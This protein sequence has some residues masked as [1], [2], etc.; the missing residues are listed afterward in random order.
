MRYATP[1]RTALASLAL[2]SVL[3]CGGSSPSA[4][5]PAKPEQ[6]PKKTDVEQAHKEFG[7]AC[8]KQTKGAGEYCECAWGQLKKILGDDLA[9]K[10]DPKLAAQVRDAVADECRAKAPESMIKDGYV[11]GCT[12]QRPEMEDYCNCT[13]TEFRKRYSV[14]DMNDENVVKGDQF[15]GARKQVVKTCG[16]KMPEAVAKDDFMKGCARDPGA[17]P[18]CSCA[19]KETRKLGAPAEIEAGLVDREKLVKAI[20]TA[21]GKLKPDQQKPGAT[22][23]ATTPEKTEKK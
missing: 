3:G 12:G 2:L 1:M 15:A 13:W 20:D 23:K 14:A 7:E 11:E 16:A 9:G 17:E 4:P 18:F 21:C 19:W 22:P 5:P 10:D 6:Q 8:G